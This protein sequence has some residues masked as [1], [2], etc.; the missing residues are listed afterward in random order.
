MLLVLKIESKSTFTKKTSGG[1]SE[2]AR[3]L[4]DEDSEIISGE[5]EARDCYRPPL[6]P[7]FSN[8][9]QII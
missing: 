2:K 8:W 3:S 7:Q 1:V 5:T 6:T 4:S 9:G